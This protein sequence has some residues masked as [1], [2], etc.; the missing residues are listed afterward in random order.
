MTRPSLGVPHFDPANWRAE[1]SPIHMHQD[2]KYRI[3]KYIY[4]ND[5]DIKE[6]KTGHSRWG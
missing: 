2:S 1:Y 5:K 4:S 3:L 6:N